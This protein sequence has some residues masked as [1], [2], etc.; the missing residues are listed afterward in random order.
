MA[1]SGTVA[2]T[3]VDVDNIITGA[4]ID[5]GVPSSD[6]T[7]EIIRVSKLNLFFVIQ[8]IANKGVSLWTIA[9]QMIGF[10]I[11]Q[12]S[13]PLSATRQNTAGQRS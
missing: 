5:C 4:I 2:T 9:K 10:K 11:G 13:Y 8:E 7:P 3:I 6:I 12:N 1:T